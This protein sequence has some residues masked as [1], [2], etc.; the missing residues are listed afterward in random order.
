MN[1]TRNL[2]PNAPV[3][4]D[5]HG[6]FVRRTDLSG[7]SLVGANLSRADATGAV[8]RDADLK[9]AN[10]NQTILR[11]AD[12]SGAKNLTVAQLSKA[13]LDETTILPDYIDRDILIGEATDR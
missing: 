6:A 12:L 2:E 1:L 13:V 10:L 11:G 8:F 4:V 9:D 7:A 5:I 3:E